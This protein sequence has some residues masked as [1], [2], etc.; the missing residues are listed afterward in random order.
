MEYSDLGLVCRPTHRSGY[1]EIQ[2]SWSYSIGYGPYPVVWAS[3]EAGWFE[4]NPAPQYRAMYDKMCQG[5]TL[6]YMVMDV[7]ET[8]RDLRKRK[9]KLS[10]GAIPLED[11]FLQVRHAMPCHAISPLNLIDLDLTSE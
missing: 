10:H 7:Y 5:I 4:I 2:K 9:K 6:Y 1:I 11:I 3:G 8:A